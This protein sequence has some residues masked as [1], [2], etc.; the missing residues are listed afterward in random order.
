MA[1]LFRNIAVLLLIMGF[2]LPL[3]GYAGTVFFG[4]GTISETEKRTLAP[5]PRLDG[6]LRDFTA[7]LDAH[8]EDHFGFRMTFIRTA[9]EIRDNLGEDPPAVVVGKDGWLFLG[10]N[11]YRDEFEGK[12]GWDETQVD[13]WIETL[14]LARS[15]LGERNVPFA[16]FIAPDKARIFPDKLPDDWIEGRRRFRTAVHG[17]PGTG[18]TGLVDAERYVRAAK[19]HGRTVF[20]HRDTHWTPDGSYDLAMAVMDELDPSTRRPRHL[21]D[22]PRIPAPR[23][24]DLEGMAGYAATSEPSHELIAFPPASGDYIE[25]LPPADPDSPARGEFATLRMQGTDAAPAGRLV[26]VGDSFADTMLEHFRPS[27]R[28]IVRLHHGAHHYDIGLK[29][30]LALDPDAVLFAT[31]ERQA[32]R[33]ARPLRLD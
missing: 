16:A 18:R 15:E 25:I 24:M 5:V 17:H 19:A 31:A 22:P 7:G 11:K 21:P 26:I 4:T 10:N 27:Y 23:L 14:A 3:A 2:L 20:F 1:R 6:S 13:A 32:A 9:R 8:F 33:K 29:D 30:V 12:G 28:E